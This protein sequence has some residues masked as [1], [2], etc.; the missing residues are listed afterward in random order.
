MSEQLRIKDREFGQRY[1]DIVGQ[2]I[3]PETVDTF[4]D[5]ALDSLIKLVGETV[6]SYD[7]QPTVRK[8]KGSDHE[9]AALSYHG[10]S[11]DVIEKTLDHIA[12]VAEETRVVDELMMAN[13][14]HVGEVIL[15][16]ASN[17]HKQTARTGESAFKKEQIPRTKTVLLIA[18]HLAGVDLR[19]KNQWSVTQGELID[20]MQRKVSYKLVD[21]IRLRRSFLICD[22]EDN[23]T[24]AF[25]TEQLGN[26]GIVNSDL[27]ALN[28][29]DIDDFSK[30]RPEMCRRINYSKNFSTE[31]YDA[32]TNQLG[33]SNH[34][35]M[36]SV[37]VPRILEPREIHNGDILTIRSFARETG[38]HAEIA[39][40]AASALG[41][42]NEDGSARK[43]TPDEQRAIVKYIEQKDTVPMRAEG[44]L[45]VPE[46]AMEL[47]VSNGSVLKV[48]M[49]AS[50]MI[51]DVAEQRNYNNVVCRFI[52]PDQQRIIKEVIEGS[53]NT[54]VAEGFMTRSA[55][56]K[57]LGVSGWQMASV[58][59][60]MKEELGAVRTTLVGGREIEYFDAAQQALLHQ[61]LV[62]KGAFAEDAPA[63]YR[64]G[65]AMA[66]AWGIGDSTIA[67]AINANKERLGHVRKW[68]FSSGPDYGYSPEDQ[69]MLHEWVVENRRK[70]V[71]RTALKRA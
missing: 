20:S 36:N 52:A 33:D 23:A 5:S 49:S 53:R 18:E 22:E 15:P 26:A 58:I 2:A 4:A 54:L 12:F 71:G 24:F 7:E 63:G 64:T 55:L 34:S 37:S 60:K 50:D 42:R 46:L 56:A 31:I 39:R 45:T 47:G 3:T 70:N 61:Y 43:V 17:R 66:R 30:E 29:D 51:G 8:A 57:T 44:Y 59:D 41:F 67:R 16:T 11:P 21:F 65:F 14:T 38:I 69:L 27:F 13:T 9:R 32:L 48:L 28:K 35:E 40:R 6:E 10:L 1:D 68:K 62:E 19:D 25:D